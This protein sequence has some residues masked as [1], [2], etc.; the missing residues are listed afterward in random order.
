MEIWFLSKRIDRLNQGFQI[1]GEPVEIKRIKFNAVECFSI[2][3]NDHIPLRRQ[4][5][6]IIVCESLIMVLEIVVSDIH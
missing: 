2:K 5:I 4:T 6:V 1:N 3:R